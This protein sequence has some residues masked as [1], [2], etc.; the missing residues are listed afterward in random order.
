MKPQQTFSVYD[1]GTTAIMDAKPK[2]RVE[3]TQVVGEHVA[4]C[5]VLEEKRLEHHRTG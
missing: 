3:V 4:V 2:G 1:K 5:R